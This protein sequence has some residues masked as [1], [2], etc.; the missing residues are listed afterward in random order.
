MRRPNTKISMKPKKFCTLCKREVYQT[1]HTANSYW[2]DWHGTND[3][4]I[5]VDCHRINLK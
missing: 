3:K 4:P 1:I 5:C 2:A